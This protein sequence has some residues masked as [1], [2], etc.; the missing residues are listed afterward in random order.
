MWDNETPPS[1]SEYAMIRIMYSE[2]TALRKR[3]AALETIINS[4]PAKQLLEF[5]PDEK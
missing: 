5:L 4:E 3:V 2:I 1:F